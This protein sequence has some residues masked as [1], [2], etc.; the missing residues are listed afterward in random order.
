M[1]GNNF[2]SILF[3]SI[4][5]YVYRGPTSFVKKNLWI[6]SLLLLLLSVPLL[7]D[8]TALQILRLKTFDVLIPEKEPSGYFSILNITEEDVAF[9]GGYPLPRVRLADIQNGLMARGALGVG[10]V[11]LFPQP[12][13]MGGDEIFANT[14]GKSPTVIAMPEFDNGVYPETHGTVIIGEER[15]GIQAKGFIENIDI[16]KDSAYQGAIT[17]PVEVDSL[18]RRIPLL[19]Q[20][21]DGWVASFGTQV[22]KILTGTETYQIKTGV[23]GIEA[24]RVKQLPPIPTDTLGRKWISWVNTPELS[25]DEMW[26][27]LRNGDQEKI[28]DRF[29]FVGVTAK[30]VMPQIATPAGL[31]EPH[32]IQAALAESLL[33]QDSPII[34]D[35]RLGVESVS[36]THLTLPTILRV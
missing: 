2:N 1:V 17:A 36:Y 28:K 15:G 29:I 6:S 31:L 7:F 24:I 8:W 12:D 3:S 10:W 27:D 30:G 5:S 21:P 19:M 25:L 4:Y 14:I 35:Y 23:N 22:L 20:T 11:I 13:R 16:L 18:L 26:T 34:P 32:K 9:E 33:I